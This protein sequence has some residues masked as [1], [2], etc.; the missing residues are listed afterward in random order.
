MAKLLTSIQKQI[1]DIRHILNKQVHD[2]KQGICE[3]TVDF[4]IKFQNFS[5]PLNMT[6]S[7][8]MPIMQQ[9]MLP[10][11]KPEIIQSRPQTFKELLEA[12]S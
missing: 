8:L 4:V 10:T 12:V 3:P 1:H 7:Q 5:R 9:N 6:E 2:M 11:L